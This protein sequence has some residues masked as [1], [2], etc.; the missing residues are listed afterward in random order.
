MSFICSRHRE[1]EKESH[2]NAVGRWK[3][4]QE[5]SFPPSLTLAIAL[6]P[7]LSTPHQQPTSRI[8][9]APISKQALTLRRKSRKQ[10]MKSPISLGAIKWGRHRLAAA[11]ATR[12]TTWNRISNNSSAS[13]SVRSMNFTIPTCVAAAA[14]VTQNTDNTYILYYSMHNIIIYISM[15]T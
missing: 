4:K 5:M 2:T 8:K 12:G 11:N 9:T 13:A 14:V 7:V 3:S 10:F 1:R 15:Y 6:A